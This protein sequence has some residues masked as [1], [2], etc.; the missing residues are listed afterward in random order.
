MQQVAVEVTIVVM[1][2]FIALEC[3]ISYLEFQKTEV[4]ALIHSAEY[5][6]RLL[7]TRA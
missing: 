1:G 3:T 7:L 6:G 2:L 5:L 4:T